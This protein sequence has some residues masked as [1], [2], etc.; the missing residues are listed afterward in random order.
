MSP[1]AVDVEGVV[2]F[3]RDTVADEKRGVG[4]GVSTAS[5]EPVGKGIGVTY[6]VKAWR[7]VGLTWTSNGSTC[8]ET[9]T[10]ETGWA[11]TGV[12]AVENKKYQASIISA[13]HRRREDVC[14]RP[15]QAKS[16][17]RT[18][19]RLHLASRSSD[20]GVVTPPATPNRRRV[21]SLKEPTS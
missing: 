8:E 1:S 18:G 4:K 21:D 12:A 5:G 20:K 11:V 17:T 9:E 10:N 16:V 14:L 7:I 6:A 13:T 15:Q 3:D 2:E 19:E